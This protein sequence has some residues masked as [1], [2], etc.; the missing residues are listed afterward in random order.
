MIDWPTASIAITSITGV[1]AFIYKAIY[2][3]KN[4]PSKPIERRT[5]LFT[6]ITTLE[7]NQKN[8]EKS[9]IEFKTDFKEDFRSLDAKIERLIIK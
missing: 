1:M 8:L 5:E 2:G 6:K 9:F 4:G 7:V 3:N